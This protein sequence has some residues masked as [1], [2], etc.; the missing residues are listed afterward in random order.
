MK[1]TLVSK[2]K[3]IIMKCAICDKSISL[4]QRKEHLDTEHNL[5]P[6]IIEWIVD[7]DDRLSK[8]EEKE[9]LYG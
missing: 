4:R 9:R 7:F 8:L 1:K 5:D 2:C 3:P 6:R